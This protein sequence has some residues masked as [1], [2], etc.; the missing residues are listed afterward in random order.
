MEGRFG[1]DLSSVKIHSDGPAGQSARDIDAEAYTVGNSVVFGA[2]R[3]APETYHGRRLLAHE[4]TH[5]LQQAGSGGRVIQRQPAGQGAGPV[6]SPAKASSK[7]QLRLEIIGSDA[8]INEPL[9]VMADRKA[10]EHGGKVLS[11]SSIEDMISQIDSLLDGNTCLGHL[12]VW[13]H[14]SPEIQ[15]L[16]GNYELPPDQKRLPASGFTRQWLQLEKN[17][18]VL[19]RFRHMFCCGGSMHWIGCGTATVRAPGG[20]RTEKEIKFGSGNAEVHPDIYQSK[21]DAIK[22]GAKLPGGSFG[23]VNVQ[24]WANATCT[25][26][27]SATNLVTLQPYDKDPKNWITID[28]GGQWVDVNPQGQCECDPDT[29]RV[30]GDAPTREEM[31]KTAL[32]QT[33]DLI[34]KENVVWH[35]GLLSL[36]TGIPHATEVIGAQSGQGDRTFDVKEGTLP[37]RLQ[38][39]MRNRPKKGRDPARCANAGELECY[40]LYLIRDLLYRA[41]NDLVPPDPL[42]KDPMPPAVRWVRISMGGTWAAVTQRHL[43]VVYRDDPWSWMVFTDRA[44]GETPAFTRTI[45]QH[46]LE[47]AAD[48]ERDLVEFEKTNPRPTGSVPQSFK[49]PQEESVIRGEKDS[50]WG[51][52]I[53]DFI[54][55]AEARTAPDR[56]LQIV[57]GQRRQKTADGKWS[58]NEWSWGERAFWFQLVFTDLPPNVKSGS[59]VQGE[60][61]VLTAFDKANSSLKRAAAERAFWTIQRAVCDDTGDPVEV[62]KRRGPARTLV[63]HF[64]P[65]VK[66]AFEEFWPTMD[67]GVAVDWLKAK[68]G[69]RDKSMACPP[70]FDA[71]ATQKILTP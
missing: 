58:W 35:E 68:P 11:V 65:I 38:Y 47:H 69:T 10:K 41:G 44:I 34:G 7:R 39:E 55:F 42:P 59:P 54:D 25:T 71:K 28:D 29:G 50:P 62:E 70:D 30:G 18:P 56:H 4:L 57:I 17:R 12:V 26:I 46:E 31:V 36:R 16:V 1:R 8:T 67:K 63:Q 60:D 61:E 53:N 9:A 20:L 64:E 37:A 23:A 24:A 13:Y 49:G 66:L 52:Y 14:G 2:G 3:F 48:L 6:P 15:L 45:I 40:Y 19:N 21:E 22:H 33:A 5:V 51:K 43:G 32:Q 27:R